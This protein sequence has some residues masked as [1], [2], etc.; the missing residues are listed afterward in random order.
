[1]DCM[2]FVL[3][4][5]MPNWTKWYHWYWIQNGEGEGPFSLIAKK[6]NKD[7]PH[8]SIATRSPISDPK[9]HRYIMTL[10]VQR[11]CQSLN[12]RFQR[13]GILD[14]VILEWKG[15]LGV[16]FNDKAFLIHQQSGQVCHTQSKLWTRRQVFQATMWP[17]ASY[18]AKKIEESFRKMVKKLIT[19]ITMKPKTT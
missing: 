14:L 5:K 4:L 13:E 12:A 10:Y 18:T 8:S 9:F 1:M 3:H 19:N 16:S 15:L 11:C 17:L 6:K 2:G 7:L